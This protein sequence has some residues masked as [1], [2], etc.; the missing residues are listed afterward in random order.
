MIVKV[1]KTGEVIEV[2]PLYNKNMLLK[3]V[4]IG[5]EYEWNEVET[6]VNTPKLNYNLN[7]ESQFKIKVN[8]SVSA[9]VSTREVN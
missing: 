9:L 5:T 2:V 8:T 4:K 1:K 3:D 7:Q 6:K